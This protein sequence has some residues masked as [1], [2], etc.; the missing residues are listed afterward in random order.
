LSEQEQ[1]LL[2]TFKDLSSQDQHSLLR[3][4]EFL[5]TG[6]TTM[7]V[8]PNVAIS[9]N[10]TAVVEEIEQPVKIERPKDERV[11]NALKRLSATYPMLEKKTLLSKASELVAQHVMFAKPAVIVI[12]DIETMFSEAY[13]K[14]VDAKR[15]K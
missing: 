13:D 7:S 5:A 8:A 2:S 9:S 1:S 14:Y 4:A 12:N 3:F 15:Q 6:K 11:V 10:E